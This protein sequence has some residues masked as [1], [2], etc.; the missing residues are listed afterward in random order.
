VIKLILFKALYEEGDVNLVVDTTE[1]GVSVPP[2][3]YGNMTNFIVGQSPSPLLEVDEQGIMAPLRFGGER[4][5]C[6]FPWSSIRAMISTKAI[7]HFPSEEEP[8]GER[9][10]KSSSP[11]KVIK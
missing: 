10:K 11:L 5:R 4:F 8:T 9:P 1:E 7:I 3:L 2:H 6:S